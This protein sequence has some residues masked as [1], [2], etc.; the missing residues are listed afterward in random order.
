MINKNK[1]IIII[2]VAIIVTFITSALIF[3]RNHLDH[4]NYIAQEVNE[5]KSDTQQ[6]EKK[7]KE[8]Y[9]KGDDY[10]KQNEALKEDLHSLS[11]TDKDCYL[12]FMKYSIFLDDY[13]DYNNQFYLSNVE[14]YQSLVI[15]EDKLDKYSESIHHDLHRI[16]LSPMLVSD[17]KKLGFELNLLV[18]VTSNFLIT[19]GIGYL[20]DL[21][22]K[23]GLGFRL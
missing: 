17:F 19:G 18:P 12:K 23:I 3:N 10:K 22:F 16:I 5:A 7:S 9:N 13:T 4:S 8:Y 1:E 21:Y 11:D 2:I 15:Y 14:F 20:N 6:H